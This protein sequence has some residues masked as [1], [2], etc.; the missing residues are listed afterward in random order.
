MALQAGA[1]RRNI[2]PRVGCHLD[3]N[4][5]DR[6]ST[7]I[8][9]ELFAQAVVLDDGA[10]RLGLVL[11]DLIIVTREM[12][13]QVK[14]RVARTVGIPPENLMV[15]ATHTHY[16]PAVFGA[17]NTVRE[18]GY[19]DWA[20]PRIAEAVE[21]AAARLEPAQIGWA[22]GSCETE[23]FCRRA[24]LSDGTVKMNPGAQNPEIVGPAGPTDP[25]LTV[26]IV[27][28]PERRP[29]A[30]VGNLALHYVGSAN[31]DISAD[32]FGAFSRS[33]RR[34]A[35]TEFVA[36]LTNGCFG[37]I[38]NVDYTRPGRSAPH[39]YYRC[40]RVANV[41]AGEAWK[42]WSTL[43]EEDFEDQPALAAAVEMVEMIPRRPTAE[44]MAW[45]REF[46]AA[47]S[48][49]SHRI[50]WTYAREYLLMEHQPE[51][52]ELPLQALRIGDGALVGLPGEVFAEIGLEIRRRSPFAINMPVGL[53]N[54]TVGYVAPD[55]QIDWGGYE[56]TLCRHVI[57]PKG[58]AQLW[59]ETAERL[60]H[61]V[62]GAVP[63]GGE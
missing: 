22:V 1:A 38:N 6:V 58:T 4:W 39:P 26:L 55:H 15:T 45:A 19:A 56:C 11:S 62:N 42:A 27:R 51:R 57:A 20:A 49:E 29:I 40:E 3:G 52:L 10:T 17:L 50:E 53:A 59:T 30:V 14:E 43:W 2:T 41:A 24:K 63:A 37:D 35:G 13:D 8:H 7:N 21:L 5:T 47:N 61:Q 60:L 54:D 9:D 12:A 23:V 31:T 36:M 34:C 33:L 46:H 28:T 44:Q 18:E 32:Y 16:A 25:T 48:L